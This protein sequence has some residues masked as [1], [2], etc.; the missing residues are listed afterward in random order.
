MANLPLFHQIAHATNRLLDRYCGIDAVKIEQV[1]SIHAQPSERALG[2]LARVHRRAVDSGHVSAV[3]V[4]A[5]REFG[6]DD[7]LFPASLD[8]AT[9]QFLFVERALD[10]GRVEEIDAQIDRLPDG[11]DRLAL[12]GFAIDEHT[13]LRRRTG[14]RSVSGQI[15]TD[16]SGETARKVPD[17]ERFRR[18]HS[19]Q[20]FHLAVNQKLRCHKHCVTLGELEKRR[21]EPNVGRQPLNPRNRFNARIV[22]FGLMANDNK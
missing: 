12:I 20:S 3:I 15:A 17:F 16:E 4:D 11:G 19:F 13:A 7:D 22:A 21:V 8:R 5:E 9:D 14:H 10:L 1:E 2:C 6:A 18:K